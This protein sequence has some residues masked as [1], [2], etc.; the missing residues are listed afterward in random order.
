VFP[1]LEPRQGTP[2][3]SSRSMLQ[4]TQPPHLAQQLNAV[5]GSLP[6]MSRQAVTAILL[7]GVLAIASPVA[8]QRQRNPGGGGGGVYRGGQG[9]GG[10]ASGAGPYRGGGR[11]VTQDRGGRPQATGGYQQ[12]RQYAA[13]QRQYAAPQQYATRPQAVTRAPGTL[14]DSTRRYSVQRNPGYGGGYVNRGYSGRYVDQ[15]YA[16]PGYAGPVY[17]RPG[18]AA[19][20]GYAVPRGYV[21]P[22]G[23]AAPR[24]YAHGYY[25]PPRY[26]APGWH[27]YRNGYVVVSP[28]YVTPYV[29]GYAPWYPYY[30]R[31]SIGIGIYYGAYGLYPFGAVAPAYYDP[32][33][34]AVLG[35]VRITDAPRDAQVFAD[36]NYVG[37][38]DDFDGVSQ[39]L[40]LEPGEHRIEIHA[41]GLTP[42]SFDVVVQAGS[43]ITLRAEIY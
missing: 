43:T 1:W 5:D 22:H 13:P 33:P 42:I 28:R 19:P 39:H 18:Y 24:G 20:K 11:A 3:R 37:I 30:Y 12:P 21:A 15:G 23:Y 41:P 9:Q 14:V 38:V 34:G 32:A 35:G 27:G 17:G 16:R 36:G 2:F 10:R 4:E 7:A 25:G 8:A 31:P 6:I 26:I 29:V 40:N